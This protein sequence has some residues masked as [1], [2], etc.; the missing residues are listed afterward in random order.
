VVKAP[1]RVTF[2]REEVPTGRFPDVF[3][4]A[5]PDAFRDSRG[6]LHVLYWLRG[7]ST[8]ASEQLRHAVVQ[9]GEL[10]ADVMVAAGS[11]VYCRIT[12]DG[13]G[14]LFLIRSDAKR[15]PIMVY[16]TTSE[17]GTQLGRPTVL[18][19][20]G[21]RIVYSGLSIAAPRMGVPTGDL[22]DGAFP[23]AEKGTYYYVQ[24]R[25]R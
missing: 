7:P 12:E 24:L 2:S 25:L 1:F 11:G 4:D 13:T 19:L 6:R 20:R 14:R 21:P 23:S 8:A 17:D 9:S 5:Q 16:P 15:S 10:V 18:D 22:V 3:C